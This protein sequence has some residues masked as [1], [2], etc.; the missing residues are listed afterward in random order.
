VIAPLSSGDIWEDFERL[1]DKIIGSLPEGLFFK[2]RGMVS[3]HHHNLHTGANA[4]R[5]LY[6]I[7]SFTIGEAIVEQQYIGFMIGEVSLRAGQGIFAV[8]RAP[9]PQSDFENQAQVCIVIYHQYLTA[10]TFHSDISAII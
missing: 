10:S 5:F 1:L 8:D 4:G 9:D 6:K 3:G 7:Q 2:V